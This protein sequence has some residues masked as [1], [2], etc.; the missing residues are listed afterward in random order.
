MCKS[1]SLKFGL[2]FYVQGVK[3]FVVLV[4]ISENSG[5]NQQKTNS[6]KIVVSGITHKKA[7]FCKTGIIQIENTQIH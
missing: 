1:L 6:H 4:S 7:F 2:I 5:E 3:L